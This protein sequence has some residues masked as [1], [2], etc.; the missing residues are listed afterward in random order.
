MG[1]KL[2]EIDDD[3][4]TAVCESCGPTTIRK[5]WIEPTAIDPKVLWLCS[6]RERGYPR[7]NRKRPSTRRTTLA[8]IK[9]PK[10]CAICGSTN[11]LVADH[12]HET[13][14][15][16]DW[17]CTDCNL[18]LGRFTDDVWKLAKA[19]EYLELHRSNA[20]PDTADNGGNWPTSAR[21]SDV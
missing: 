3:Q 12:C 18:G 21:R 14:A 6:H 7:P 2:T 11:R 15:L 16:R 4:L 17:L 19:I 9:P 13:E 1:H 5:R 20:R 10:E 8:E